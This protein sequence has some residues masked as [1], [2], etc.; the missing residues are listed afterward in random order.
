M[1]FM[2]CASVIVA[3][4]VTCGAGL[5]FPAPAWGETAVACGTPLEAGD[6][7]PSGSPEEA[8]LD[9]AILCSLNE[10][11]D[12]SPDMNVDAVVVVRGGKL[13]YETYRSGQDQRWGL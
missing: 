7:W 13:I 4:S 5:Q 3:V 12:K 10:T 8:G 6:E 1:A 11:L 9:A 2:R